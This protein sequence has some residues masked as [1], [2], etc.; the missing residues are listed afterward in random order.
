MSDAPVP[1]PE[2]LLLA[3]RLLADM[4]EGEWPGPLVYSVTTWGGASTDAE[5][6]AIS[7]LQ[8]YLYAQDG[9]GTTDPDLKE[10]ER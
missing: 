7:K 1:S 9:R 8:A 4:V 5:I 3:A 10:N 6:G 2:E